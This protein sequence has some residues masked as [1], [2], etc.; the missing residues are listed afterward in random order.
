M[1]VTA[2]ECHNDEVEFII[3]DVNFLLSMSLIPFLNVLLLYLALCI[4]IEQVK[5]YL[6]VKSIIQKVKKNV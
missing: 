6:Y 5:S 3:G 2:Y 1:Y 4:L